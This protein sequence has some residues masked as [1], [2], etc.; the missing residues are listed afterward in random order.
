MRTEL[1]RG[2]ARC[3]IGGALIL[4]P[5]TTAPT[6]AAASTSR[7][8]VPPVDQ[9]RRDPSFQRF[10]KALARGF[11]TRD[12]VVVKK[13]THPNIYVA[14]VGARSRAVFLARLRARPEL[15]P[16]LLA[17][18]R[19][20]GRFIGRDRFR[21]PYT[22]FIRFGARDPASTGV[23]VGPQVTIRERPDPTAPATAIRGYELV[24]VPEWRPDYR[25]RRVEGWRFVRT[26][27]GR[28]GYVR[29]GDV[30]YAVTYTLD[31]IRIRGI[32]WINRFDSS[33]R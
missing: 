27:D 32:W 19:K 5:A 26:A 25:G 31:F 23:L 11:A 33:F 2:L 29:A 7:V 18:L 21:A 24:T 10:R 6:P 22:A 12:L 15:W 14:T 13:Y 3:L 20:G 9:G 17:V 1:A 8:K 30:D 16:E 4:A 28:A